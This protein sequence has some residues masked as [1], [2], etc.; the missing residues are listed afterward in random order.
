M[1]MLDEV[2]CRTRQL[3]DLSITVYNSG[4]E[5]SGRSAT[6]PSPWEYEVPDSSGENILDFIC[7]SAG[8]RATNPAWWQLGAGIVPDRYLVQAIFDS[9][10]GK[11]LPANSRGAQ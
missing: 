2:N 7:S 5:P 1:L 3:R 11:P 10:A 9:N 4:G 8:A 6:K